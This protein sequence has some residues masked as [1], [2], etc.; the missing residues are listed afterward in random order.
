[1]VPST[2]DRHFRVSHILLA[3]FA[4]LEESEITAKY[5][6]KK[7]NIGHIVRDKHVI[8]SLSRTYK[9]SAFVYHK[10]L[11]FFKGCIQE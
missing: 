7:K 1:M 8:T 2:N 6:E 10:N 11:S 5:E 3:H 9:I 4:S